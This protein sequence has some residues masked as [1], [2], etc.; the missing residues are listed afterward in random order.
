M[1]PLRSMKD[2]KMTMGGNGDELH[3]DRGDFCTMSLAQTTPRPA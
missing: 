1:I 2:M 3:I